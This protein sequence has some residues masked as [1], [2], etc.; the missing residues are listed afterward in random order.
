LW[1]FGVALRGEA[2]NNRELRRLSAVRGE[3]HGKGALDASC[4]DQEGERKRSADEVSKHTETTSKPGC[5][6]DP[7][8]SLAVTRLPAR[9]CP[10][11]RRRE[12]DLRLLHGT[13]EGVAPIPLGRAGCG[14]VRGSASS[15]RN[16]EALSTVAGH[17]GGP[18][19][20]SGETP[21]MGVERR[22]RVARDCVRSINWASSREESH[23]RVEVDRKAV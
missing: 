12:P 15:G 22:G 6:F 1:P 4:G 16:R 11:W 7:G 3:R 5:H 10:A 19:R 8:M 14:L 17:A 9:W 20:S 13:W 18:A 2:S 21:V 23:G